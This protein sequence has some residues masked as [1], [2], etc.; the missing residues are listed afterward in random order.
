MNINWN[1]LFVIMDEL[2]LTNEEA[3]QMFGPIPRLEKAQELRINSGIFEPSDLDRE[4]VDLEPHRITIA[5]IRGTQDEK[6]E[7]ERPPAKRGRKT[8]KIKDA[9]EDIPYEPVPVAQF[10][11]AHSVSLSVLRRHRNFDHR[12]E[13]GKVNVRLHYLNEGDKEKTL[14]IWREKPKD[15]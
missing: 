13:L 10:R 14:C 4:S 3:Q 2:E 7:Q 6:A 8:R 5:K 9:Y 15:G 12:P 11:E 1:Q